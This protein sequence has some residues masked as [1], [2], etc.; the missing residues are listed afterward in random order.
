[1]AGKKTACARVAENFRSHVRVRVCR[2]VAP[3]GACCHRGI[4][5][6][7]HFAAE[8]RICASI[9]HHEQ[10]EV[11]GLSADLESNAAAFERKH[12]WRA[13]P[14]SEMLAG[15]ANHGAAAI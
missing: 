7:F 12:G 13:P 4:A 14:S 9:I 15:A 3:H 1:N 5:A 8:N 6:Q 10:H 2:S 11:G